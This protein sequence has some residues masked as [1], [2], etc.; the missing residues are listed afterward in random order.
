MICEN[1]PS[2][3]VCLNLTQGKDL[4]NPE[5]SH[6]LKTNRSHDIPDLFSPIN[7]NKRAL[8]AKS[9][10]YQAFVYCLGSMLER[11]S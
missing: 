11:L 3:T 1:P 4:Q 5:C 8:K 9:F 2:N 6:V 10:K 7:I